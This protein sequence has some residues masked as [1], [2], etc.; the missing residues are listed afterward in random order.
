MSSRP[1]WQRT[2]SSLPTTLGSDRPNGPP[3]IGLSGPVAPPGDRPAWG[4]SHWTSPEVNALR[5]GLRLRHALA[6]PGPW[7]AQG[8]RASGRIL[9]ATRGE[10]TS[11]SRCL[12]PIPS[13]PP[14]PS[15]TSSRS[16]PASSSTSDVIFTRTPSSPGRRSGRPGSWPPGWPRQGPG[17]PVWTGP[18]WSPR[19]VTAARSS[20][21]APTLTRCPSRTPRGTPGRAWFPVSPTRAATTC[22]P[23]DWWGRRWRWPRPTREASSPESSGSSSSPPR[24]SCPVAPCG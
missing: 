12:T 21:C 2:R 15:S 13:S 18:V 11:T 16:T 3:E 1:R 6:D 8:S 4:S 23:P 24:R 17:S 10:L 7:R 9:P 19:S 22:T 20:P 14:A 5:A